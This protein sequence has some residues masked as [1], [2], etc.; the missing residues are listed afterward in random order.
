MS[1]RVFISYRRSDTEDLAGR[2]GDRLSATEGIDEVFI[3][4]DSIAPGEDF[5]DKIESSLAKSSVCLLLIGPDWLGRDTGGGRARIFDDDDF[6]RLEVR[7]ALASGLKVLPV[8]VNDAP[9]PS[10]DELPEDLHGL[11][12]I[13]ATSIRPPQFNRDFEGVL[14][15]LLGKRERN[16]T[17]SFLER[18][19]LLGRWLR[20]LG[21][22]LIAAI[23]LFVAAI[24]HN[25]ATGGRSLEETFGGRAQVWLLILAIV[26]LGALAPSAIRRLGERRRSS[27]NRP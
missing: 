26:A 20:R 23:A 21:G 24:A 8:L 15:A 2:I 27:A 4:V 19:L 3:D 14:E 17:P 11:P 16:G 6:V 13:N 7:A 22:A 12:R 5:E 25:E 18:H 1:A 9:M 10:R